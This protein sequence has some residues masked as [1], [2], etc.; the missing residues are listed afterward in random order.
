MIKRDDVTVVQLPSAPPID[1]TVHADVSVEDRLFGI[2]AGIEEPGEL[3]KLA[4]ADDLAADRDIVEGCGFGHTKML[5]GIP[6]RAS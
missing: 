6:E 3:Q 2:P 1:F 4:E 5:S